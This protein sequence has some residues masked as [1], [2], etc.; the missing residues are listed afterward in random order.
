M[1]PFARKCERTNYSSADLFAGVLDASTGASI[2]GAGA[3]HTLLPG[4]TIMGTENKYI[5]A[6][7]L[8]LCPL[9]KTPRPAYIKTLEKVLT[10]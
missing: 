3:G 5:P 10:E 8:I 7:V 9:A 6:G 4:S 2:C 1:L